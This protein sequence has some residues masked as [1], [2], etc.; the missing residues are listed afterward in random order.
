MDTTGDT[1]L[2]RSLSKVSFPGLR[3][4]WAIGPE[5]VI[6]RMMEAKHLSDLHSDQLSQA[7]LLRFA[8]SGRLEAHH[9]RMLKAGAERLKAVLACCERH[10][11]GGAK[12]TRPE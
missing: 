11:P 3:I 6:G 4:G 12:F 10:L 8:T 1:L 5:A 9:G 2:V 7:V